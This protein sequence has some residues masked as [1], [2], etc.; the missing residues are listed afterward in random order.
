MSNW[1]DL[2]PRVISGVAMAAVAALAVWLGGPVLLV[3]LAICAGLMQWE[4]ARICDPE[5]KRAAIWLGVI[6]GIPLLSINFLDE[7]LD[8]IG[9]TWDSFVLVLFAV[10][11]VLPSIVGLFLLSKKRKLH[12]SYALAIQ[13]T[14]IV[15][16][17]LRET[18]SAFVLLFLI[19][20]VV[21][22]DVAGY[23]AGR[24]IGGP[25]FWPKISPK[26]TWSGTIAGWIGA[27]IFA[28]AFSYFAKAESELGSVLMFMFIAV[29]LSFAGQMGDIVE[30]AMK[31]SA[32]IKDSSNLIPGHGGFLDRFDAIIGAC[33]LGAT[34]AVVMFIYVVIVGL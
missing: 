21:I 20:V 30:S 12:A 7:F 4:L 14:A 13:I 19:G 25:K 27:A 24:L 23:F 32:G 11:I 34:M 16:I 1:S 29:L 9:S 28:W 8:L 6:G 3:M 33:V 31:R 22:T 2:A 10:S 18:H 17:V 5:K 15:L 26:K